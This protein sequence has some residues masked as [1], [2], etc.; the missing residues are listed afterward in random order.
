MI[1]QEPLPYCFTCNMPTTPTF[2][3]PLYR[4]LSYETPARRGF[5]FEQKTS[6]VDMVRIHDGGDRHNLERL[7]DIVLTQT[8]L[9]S[10]CI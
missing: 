5:F 6:A 1:Y 8:R 3:P 9:S 2:A 4:P 10:D 7:L